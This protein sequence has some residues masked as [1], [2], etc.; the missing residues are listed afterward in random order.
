MRQRTNRPRDGWA[1]AAEPTGQARTAAVRSGGCV[2]L[3]GGGSIAASR[4]GTS[5]KLRD[6]APQAP[7][8]EHLPSCRPPQP[9]GLPQKHCAQTDVRP[10]TLTP[11]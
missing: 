11:R 7:C 6:A 8:M 2:G 1:L 5:D 10:Q 9:G 4:A 3:T